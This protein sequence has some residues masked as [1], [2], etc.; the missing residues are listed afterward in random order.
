MTDGRTLLAALA[1]GTALA[2]AAIGAAQSPPAREGDRAVATRVA[3]EPP[4]APPAADPE[5]IREER[6]LAHRRRH[7]PEPMTAREIALLG[8]KLALDAKGRERLAELAAEYDATWDAL[9]EK[10]GRAM[11]VLLPASFSYDHRSQDLDPV[12]TPELLA[13]LRL[14]ERHLAAV[15]E[16]EARLWRELE[17]LTEIERRGP[18]RSLRL[19]RA[20]TLHDHPARLPAAG[21]DLAELVAK[22]G[23]TSDEI[24]SLA[25]PIATYREE[26]EKALRKR[27]RALRELE[28]RQT[29]E[30]VNLGPEWRAGR[31]DAEALAVDRQFATYA[32][33]TIL[34]DTELR[35]LNRATLESMRKSLLPTSARRLVEA[36]QR[37]VHPALF[38]DERAFRRL[39]EAAIALPI[40]GE[41]VSLASLELLAGVEDRLRPSGN[42]AV[43]LADGILATEG[44]PPTDAA[45]ARILL[46]VKLQQTLAKRRAN[47]RDAVN[48]LRMVLPPDR[49]EFLAKV[50]D[51]AKTIAAQDRAGEFLLAGLEA[52]LGE[53]EALRALGEEPARPQAEPDASVQVDPSAPEAPPAATP[54]RNEATKPGWPSTRGARGS[55]GGR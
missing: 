36:Y 1:F 17:G 37:L 15:A 48:Q 33:A 44:L 27:D 16:T 11:L 3:A 49:V 31:T 20:K 9:R 34:A 18:F 53:V 46:E 13:F 8:E 43:D 14:R 32:V 21:V 25:V 29:E 41:E 39:V 30:L 47:I 5:S 23:L 22:S 19:D 35:D 26:L 24:A 12:H 50:E 54:P 52:R 51:A 38:E 42:A 55:R 6:E 45:M 10:D 40:G 4:A 2:P 28:L 7:L